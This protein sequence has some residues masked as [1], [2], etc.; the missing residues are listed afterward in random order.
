MTVTRKQH[1]RTPDSE[2]AVC[3]KFQER[4][5]RADPRSSNRTVKVTFIGRR[6]GFTLF[7]ANGMRHG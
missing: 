6:A 2:L 4:R 7:L 5:T 3:G 1:K